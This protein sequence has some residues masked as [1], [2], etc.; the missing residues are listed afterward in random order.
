MEKRYVGNVVVDDQGTIK[1]PEEL[2]IQPHQVLWVLLED[3]RIVL[4]IPDVQELTERFIEVLSRGLAGTTWEE[5]RQE[6]I[7]EDQEREQE[8]NKWAKECGL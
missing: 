5:I 6:R 8:I 3:G 7:S 2:N 4:Q 1:L